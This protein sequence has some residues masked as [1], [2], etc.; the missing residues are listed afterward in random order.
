MLRVGAGEGVDDVEV[1]RAEILGHLGAQRVVALLLER[2]VHLAPPDAVLGAALARDELVLGRPAR[3]PAGVDDE[4]AAVGEHAFVALQRVGVEH[5]RRRVP[6]DRSL[7]LE[8]V[9]QQQACRS[10]CAPS[11]GGAAS[12]AAGT[13]RGRALPGFAH[14]GLAVARSDPARNRAPAKPAA[15]FRAAKAA[16]R[17]RAA[18]APARPRP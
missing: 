10:P 9:A 3:V 8:A 14:P 11:Y 15:K 18:R 2:L 6:P 16:S 5:R 7:R 17:R 1:A 12:L 4:R 13:T